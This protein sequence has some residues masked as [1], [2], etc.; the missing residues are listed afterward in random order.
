MSTLALPESLPPAPEPIY[1]AGDPVHQVAIWANLLPDEL[2]SARRLTALKRRLALALAALLVLLV[3][4][5]AYSAWSTSQ[6]RDDLGRAQLK[7]AQL[8]HKQSEYTPLVTA[9]SSA[10]RI[11]T[12][13]RQLMAGDLQWTELL[14][15]LRTSA[16]PGV[17][18]QNVNATIAPATKTSGLG[19]LNQSGKQ[20]VG[21]ITITGSAPDK[22][23]LAAYVDALAAVKGLAAPF[24]ASAIGQSGGLSFSINVLITSDAL[25]GRF[26]LP[27]TTP[28]G[29]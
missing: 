6:A 15:V 11:T 14:D 4:A 17:T 18:I 8:Q 19:V 16:A 2:I 27:A 21:T 10:E 22:S 23:T 20:Q 9:Q 3:G 25:G 26:G 1:P 24:P 7:A 29:K 5:Y 12:S 28:G 13:L